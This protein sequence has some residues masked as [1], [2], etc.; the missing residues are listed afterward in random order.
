MLEFGH[1]IQNLLGQQRLRKNPL[2][3]KKLLP[4]KPTG[5]S[6]EACKGGN[7][8]KP[9]LWH[10]EKGEGV[11]LG[12]RKAFRR[13]GWSQERFSSTHSEKNHPMLRTSVDDRWTFIVNINLLM[14]LCTIRLPIL[15][16]K[17]II[18][19]SSITVF[20]PSTPME[21]LTV[22]PEPWDRWEV[23]FKTV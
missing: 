7:G 6:S 22:R 21:R 2:T 18:H 8:F 3:F 1:P 16:V 4:E 10:F 23:P 19:H 20:L 15:F 14:A 13:V 17:N 9:A 11:F 12:V 5:F